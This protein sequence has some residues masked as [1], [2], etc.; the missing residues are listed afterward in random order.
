M[1]P[2]CDTK[3]SQNYITEHPRCMTCGWQDYT[4]PLPQTNSQRRRISQLQYIGFS[5]RL[6]GMTVPIR[7]KRDESKV[8]VSTVPSCPWDYKDMRV[9][10]SSGYGRA[11]GGRSNE[12]TYRCP[13]RHRII[14]LGSS[15]GDWRG[16]M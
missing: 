13:A 16:W 2:R 14:L 1:C 9:V 15:N 5:D 10:A 3:L 11:K 6:E 7:V 8:G 4:H 12:R